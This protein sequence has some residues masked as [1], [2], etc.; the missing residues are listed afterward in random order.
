MKDQFS[1]A[2]KRVLNDNKLY[3]DMKP[4]WTPQHQSAYSLLAARHGVHETQCRLQPGK[5]ADLPKTLAD[6]VAKYIDEGKTVV[7]KE[8]PTIVADAKTVAQTVKTDAP[9][10]AADT[11]KV[12]SKVVN[13]ATT[14]STK[15]AQ[16]AE[17]A[18]AKV[19]DIAS[20]VESLL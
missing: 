20:K 8:K 19:E 3:V 11:A 6:Q 15:V 17:T 18:K 4:G 13:D 5:L 10:V 9:V 1:Q 7:A 16:A 14:I 12:A 2:L